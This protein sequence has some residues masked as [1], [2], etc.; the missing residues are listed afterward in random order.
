VN[1][2]AA[3]KAS[4]IVTPEDARDAL[5]VTLAEVKS[6]KTGKPVLIR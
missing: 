1:C 3:G 5:K 4:T 6:V 2:I